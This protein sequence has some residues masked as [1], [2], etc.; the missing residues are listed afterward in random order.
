MV[1]HHGD[2]PGGGL[3]MAKPKGANGAGV[4]SRAALLDSNDRPVQLLD[5]PA[6]G[7]T[8]YVRKLSVGDALAVEATEGFEMVRETFRRSLV[9]AG[10]SPLFPANDREA[11]DA[12]MDQR[13]PT[14]FFDVLDRIKTINKRPKKE[15]LAGK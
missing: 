3:I 14:V 11:F 8:V 1:E 6:W 2:C 12:W 5:V 9:D 7:G 13:D 10:G 15:E 4:L